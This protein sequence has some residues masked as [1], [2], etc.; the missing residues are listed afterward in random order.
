MIG[1]SDR[2]PVLR[3]YPEAP[4]AEGVEDILSDVRGVLL[5]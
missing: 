1:R 2:E 4:T 3:V 5:G